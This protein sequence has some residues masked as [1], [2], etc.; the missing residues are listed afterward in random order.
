M[1]QQV[2][3]GFIEAVGASVANKFT[4]GGAATGFIGWLA[5]V[6]WIGLAGVLIALAG[7]AANYYFQH[8]RDKREQEESAARIQALR[9][10]CGLEARRP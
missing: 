5:Q 2:H 6:N 3:E 7:L 8:R 9:E 4:F 10:Q 1:A